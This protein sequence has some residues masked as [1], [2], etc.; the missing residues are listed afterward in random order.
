MPGRV[1]APQSR[2]QPKL[3]LIALMKAPEQC[4]FRVGAIGRMARSPALEE[5]SMRHFTSRL[6]TGP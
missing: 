1:G 3:F 4:I 5:I 2:R 6:T